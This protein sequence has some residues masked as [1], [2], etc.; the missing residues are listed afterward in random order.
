MAILRSACLSANDTSRI[1]KLLLECGCKNRDS[2]S[3]RGST[4]LSSSVGA[5]VTTKES[6]SRTQAIDTSD[7]VLFESPGIVETEERV[8]GY[9]CK[10][11]GLFRTKWQQRWFELIKDEYK[12]LYYIK[13]PGKF[14]HRGH[15]LLRGFVLFSL[16]KSYHLSI[17]SIFYFKRFQNF[18]FEVENNIP[19]VF[20][21]VKTTLG[22]S[23]SRSCIDG[24][25]LLPHTHTHTYIYI[26]VFPISFSSLSLFP[27]F[28]STFLPFE[29]IILRCPVFDCCCFCICCSG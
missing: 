24:L 14:V 10:L 9:L 11:G 2:P 8:C 16:C 1:R 4:P 15:I 21:R 20:L 23:I 28:L 27:L 26:Y 29:I 5:T 25:H 19:Q 3:V 17:S 13:E 18:F 12:L 6:S 7:R 22:C